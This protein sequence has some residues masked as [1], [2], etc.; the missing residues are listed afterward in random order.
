MFVLKKLLSKICRLNEKTLKRIGN[1]SLIYSLL[2]NKDFDFK[3]YKKTIT[4]SNWQ[5]E[6][7]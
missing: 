6:S 5:T 3:A 4:W 2:I 1:E 7:L